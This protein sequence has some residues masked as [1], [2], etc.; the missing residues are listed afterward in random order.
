MKQKYEK[1]NKYKNVV[2]WSE[3]HYIIKYSFASGEI[4]IK[5]VWNIDS[6]V[7]YNNF[8]KWKLHLNSYLVSDINF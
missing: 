3:N 7:L 4:G 5:E 1:Y 2:D 8:R 6:S